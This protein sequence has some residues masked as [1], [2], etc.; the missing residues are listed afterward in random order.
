MKRTYANLAIA[1]PM[2]IL[3]FGS[4]VLASINTPD[5]FPV[6]ATIGLGL[7]MLFGVVGWWMSRQVFKSL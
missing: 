4:L 6:G 5:R 7:M 3:F 1:V 2:L